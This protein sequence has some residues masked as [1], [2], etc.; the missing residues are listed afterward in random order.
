VLDLTLVL[1][2]MSVQL[3][4]VQ[5]VVEVLDCWKQRII[6]LVVAVC[7]DSLYSRWQWLVQSR[8]LSDGHSYQHHHSAVL[9]MPYRRQASLRLRGCVSMELAEHLVNCLRLRPFYFVPQLPLR[10]CL[11]GTL[12][13]SCCFEHT[14]ATDA[15]GVTQKAVERAEAQGVEQPLHQTYRTAHWS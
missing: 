15:V 2:V 8:M 1:H 12:G 14:S 7:R 3:K 11:V 9:S 5:E 13:S 10:G 6:L 4:S